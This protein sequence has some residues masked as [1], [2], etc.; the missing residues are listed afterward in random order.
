MRT[1]CRHD[2]TTRRRSRRG[3]LGI[4]AALSVSVVMQPLFAGAFL[5]H[6]HGDEGSHRHRIPLQAAVAEMRGAASWHGHE[7][8]HEHAH[9]HGHE[10]G[11]VPEKFQGRPLL[12]RPALGGEV[13]LCEAE[14]VLVRGN[15]WS[16][17]LHA[18][19]AA[20]RRRAT[21]LTRLGCINPDLVR[22][23]DAPRDG[24][25]LAPNRP[26]KNTAVLVRTSAAL[27]L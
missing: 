20:Q 26:S 11:D 15:G 21:S 3:V 6:S 23:R 19:L 25:S 1:G 7:H 5:T 24:P 10:P 16:R 18:D 14:S 27:L 12:D 9:E 13:V 4:V 2:H 8:G 17:Y 22:L